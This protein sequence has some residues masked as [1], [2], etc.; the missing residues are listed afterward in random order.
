[1]HWLNEN[2]MRLAAPLGG[3]IAVIAA[4]LSYYGQKRKKEGYPPP[5]VNKNIYLGAIVLAIAACVM[6]GIVLSHNFG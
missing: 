5:Y 3:V 4:L 2:S 1:M 6:V